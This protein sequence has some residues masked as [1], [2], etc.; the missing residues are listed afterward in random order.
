MNLQK[1]PLV[2]LLW[3]TVQRTNGKISVFER[4]FSKIFTYRRF[5][6]NFRNLKY[7]LFPS[8]VLDGYLLTFSR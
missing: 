7:D 5:P 4:S 1:E 3:K 6:S 2:D 8:P